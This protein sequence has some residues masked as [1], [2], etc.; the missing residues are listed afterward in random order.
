MSAPVITVQQDNSLPI[1]HLVIP[2]IPVTRADGTRS[3]RHESW[4]I[5]VQH[6]L[7]G[8]SDHGLHTPLKDGPK[9]WLTGRNKRFVMKH[10]DRMVIATEFLSQY[11]QLAVG[12][13]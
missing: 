2:D 1:P 9:A 3:P 5:V 4:R 10:H 13:I 8:D 11:V 7:T 12:D 6:W